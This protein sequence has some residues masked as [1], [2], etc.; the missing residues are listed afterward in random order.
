MGPILGRVSTQAGWYPDASGISVLRWWDGGQWTAHTTAVPADT[1]PRLSPGW[2]ALSTWV[3]VGIAVVVLADVAT[4]AL[5]AHELTVLR[6]WADDPASASVSQATAMD[7]RILAM[8]IIA[9]IS[10][11][12]SGVLFIAWLYQAHRSSAMEA[13]Q[14]RHGSGWAIGGWFVPI[15]V[16]W[17]P[18]QMV[19]D[20]HRG[21]TRRSSALVT[22]WWVMFMV[23]TVMERLVSATSG[24]IDD[25]DTIT[26][27]LDAYT[28]TVS[29]SVAASIGEVL[30]GVLAIAVVARVRRAVRSAETAHTR[31]P[32]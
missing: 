20:V 6:S 16:L 10:M 7:H 19:Q 17:R 27:G 32:S 25:A 4:S 2:F 5:M 28:D 21:A 15:L 24:A 26:E 30:A 31:T 13:G 11:I 12:A 18:Y 1:R 9:G 29:A 8:G 3:Q 14:L 22:W 23:A